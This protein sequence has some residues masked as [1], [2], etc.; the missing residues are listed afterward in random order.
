M[1][2]AEFLRAVA[3]TMPGKPSASRSS[4]LATMAPRL[5]LDFNERL[6]SAAAADE[7]AR[8]LH[9]MPTYPDLAEVVRRAIDAG[10]AAPSRSPADGGWHVL[11]LEWVGR[12]SG[13]NQQLLRLS[14]AKTHGAPETWDE[15]LRLYRP[16]IEQHRPHWLPFDPAT[17]AR[18]RIP[19]LTSVQQ[20][21]PAPRGPTV[22]TRPTS[23][24]EAGV[25]PNTYSDRALL[26]H[27]EAA[28]N[29][30]NRA[31]AFRAEQ[32][33]Q[34]LGPD[35]PEHVEFVLQGDDA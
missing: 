29:A 4:Q 6:L 18:P 1:T 30:G 26:A 32:L 8:S 33:R 10:P 13:T 2:A 16:V 11:W 31:A 28:A 35:E 17:R 12:S 9:G 22:S 3:A 34:R 14:V 15:L 25:R 5:K 23:Q 27:Y 20:A 7:V 24:P 21:A 19:H